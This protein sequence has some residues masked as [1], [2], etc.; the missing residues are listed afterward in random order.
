VATVPTAPASAVAADS[1]LDTESR[2]TPT[3]VAM[4]SIDAPSARSARIPA[5][6]SGVSFDGPFGPFC[7]G[8]SPSAPSL[9]HAAI[10]RCTVASPAPKAAPASTWVAAPVSTSCTAASRRATTSPASQHHA[11]IPHTNTAPPSSHSTRWAASDTR[12]DPAG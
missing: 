9:R 11:A 10:H 4:A 3:A 5:T 12:T 7:A 2:L 8:A 6:R 1:A